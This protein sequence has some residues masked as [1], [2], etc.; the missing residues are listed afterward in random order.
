MA[1]FVYSNR[2]MSARP[3]VSSYNLPQ[4]PSLLKIIGPSFILLGLALG[5]GELIMWPYLSSR[6]GLGLIWGG[7]LGIT[8]QFILNTETMRYAL[9]WGES[10]FVGFRKISRII[11][12]WYVLST[13]IP[14][15][16]PGFSSASAEIIHHFFPFLNERV[17]AIF[18]LFLVGVILSSGQTLYKTIE[19]IQKTNI[20]ISFPFIVILVLLFSNQT[21]WQE[22]SRGLVG[23]GN[24]WLFFPEGLSLMAF[25]G[26]FAYSGAGGNLNLAQSYYIK[27]KGFGMGKFSAGI[28]SLFAAGAE[29]IQISGHTFPNTPANRKTWA[30]WWKLMVTEHFLV[31]WLLGFLIISI[32]SVLSRSLLYGSEVGS[33]LSFLFSQAEAMTQASHF[34]IGNTFLLMA[35][36]MLFFTHLGI[37]E[38]SS[39]IISENIFLIFSKSDKQKANLSSGFYVA[40]WSQILLG[41]GIYLVGWQEP[42]F[43]LTLAAI[44]NAGAM[45]V[46]FPLIY[47]LNRRYL[48]AEYQPHLLRKIA[49]LAATLFFAF[50]VFVTFRGM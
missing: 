27:E 36:A 1:F 8:F 22:Y 23:Q 10:V 4:P 16:L 43:L 21:A 7:L 33:G 32:M 17:T 3:H 44:L 50:F 29:K 15:S 2:G 48:P 5:S 19:K 24:G 37:L 34:V 47:W 31:F 9:A 12:F 45:M 14:W 38:S 20:G 18:L 11:P 46:S 26:A 42:R 41:V 13:F 30:K 49:M 40:L 6:Y 28:R 25:L 39:R 35:A